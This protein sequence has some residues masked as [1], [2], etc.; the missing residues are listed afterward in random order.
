MDPATF[1]GSAGVFGTRIGRSC[2]VSPASSGMS[3]VCDQA[4]FLCTNQ[5]CTM[6]WIQAAAITFRNVASWNCRPRQELAGSRDAGWDS[7]CSR[8]RETSR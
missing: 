5:S 3:C 1:G 6:N 7:S 2:Q 8:C 4:P